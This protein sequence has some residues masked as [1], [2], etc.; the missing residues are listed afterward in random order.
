MPENLRIVLCCDMV[1]FTVQ[2]KMILL[3]KLS[4]RKHTSPRHSLMFQFP[5]NPLIGKKHCCLMLCH[6]KKH[7][8]TS[9]P[10]ILSDKSQIILT[11]LS[12]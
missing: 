8:E 1:K 6:K 10:K 4:R 11:V 7:N 3:M 2:N 5:L 12:A 9:V